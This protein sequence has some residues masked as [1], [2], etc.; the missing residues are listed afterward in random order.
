VLPT[1]LIVDDDPSVLDTMRRI[2]PPEVGLA[3]AAD[4]AQASKLLAEYAYCG[5]V[6]DL[7]LDESSGLDVLRFMKEQN[8]DVPCVVV[9]ANLPSYVREMLDEDQVKLVLPKPVEEKLLAAVVLGLC[10]MS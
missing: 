2:L 9:S 3:S 6:L 7:V 4:A 8:L 1:V 10:G 5:L